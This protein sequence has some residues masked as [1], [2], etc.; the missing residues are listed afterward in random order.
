[1]PFIKKLDKLI[2]KAF[3]GPFAVTFLVTLFILLLQF[4]WL[5]LD[6]FVGKGIDTLT[7][8]EFV[9]Y[10]LASLVPL[11]LPLGMLLSSI[12]T[13][14]N[15]GESFEL[16]AIKSA[17]IPLLRF[18]RPIFL[19]AA[20]LSVIAFLFANYVIP[21][22]E[23]KM[24][25]LL[26]DIRVSKPAFDI[27]EGVFYD[28]LEGYTIKIGKKINDSTIRDVVVYETNYGLQDNMIIAEEGEMRISPDKQ[29]LYFN[30]RNGWRYQ[31]KGENYTAN[32]EF[33]RL[34]FKEYKKVFDLSSFKLSKTADSTFKAYYKM[35]SLK[36]LTKVID[37]LQRKNKTLAQRTKKDVSSQM[38]F[39]TIPDSIWK[40]AKAPAR[41][42]IDSLIPDSLRMYVA[43]HVSAK[44]AGIRSQ[45]EY[46]ALEYHEQQ[47]QMRM[48]KLERHRKF[49]LSLACIVLF[50]IGAPLGSIIRKGGIGLP[51]VVSVIFFIFYHIINKIGEQ[52][53]IQ[54][55]LQPFT[56]MWL[57]TI[58]LIPVGLWLTWKAMQDAQIL[59]RAFYYKLFRFL[60]IDPRKGNRQHD[61][62]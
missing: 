46:L 27:K 21:V 47:K 25:T 49:S 59:N 3:I 6:D 12:M 18:M 8:L 45:L 58:L 57:S 9:S 43:N 28:K 5:Y 39:A 44:L 22:A 15:L 54:D 61:K 29:F 34:G 51:L 40:K 33:I 36:Q 13:F 42:P 52:F 7:L 26:Y 11:A 10:L 56:G 62:A 19:T 4:F 14:G 16:V 23:L 41:A 48:H 32:T 1:M 50:L 38:P 55:V 2:L 60:K 35:L 37:S 20:F 24:R 31:E 17:G 53:I 30:L